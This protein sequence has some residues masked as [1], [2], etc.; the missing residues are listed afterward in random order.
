MTDKDY[1]AETKELE[2]RAEAQ[3]PGV[4]EL[5]ETYSR[6]SAPADAWQGIN[7]PVTRQASGTTPYIGS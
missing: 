3:S 1:A 4:L 2:E 5:L 7:Q 6:A